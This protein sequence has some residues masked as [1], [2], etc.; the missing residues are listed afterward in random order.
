MPSLTRV[1]SG[2]GT[3]IGIV[4]NRK[5]NFGDLL[6]CARNSGDLV[7]CVRCYESTGVRNSHKHCEKAANPQLW[8]K[9]EVEDENEFK[10]H[11]QD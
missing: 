4:L 9:D 6:L 5:R 1:Q 11:D 3:K 8:T 7:F 10:D 2:P